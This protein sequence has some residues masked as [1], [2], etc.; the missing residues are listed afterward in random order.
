[1]RDCGAM[2][3]K[4][5]GGAAVF[6]G[7]LPNSPAT[8]YHCPEV[9]WVERSEPHHDSASGTRT[10]LIVLERVAPTPV[11]GAAGRKRPG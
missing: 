10:I 6:S 8:L 4:L 7:L 2:G 3:Y 9:G 5:Q 11:L 1:M